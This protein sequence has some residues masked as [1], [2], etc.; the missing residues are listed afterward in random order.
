MA[1]RYHRFAP[2]LKYLVE[3]DGMYVH[4]EQ[5]GYT[6]GQEA[7]SQP[8]LWFQ[9]WQ[10]ANDFAKKSGGKVL[11]LRVYA[12]RE[13]PRRDNKAFTGDVPPA[14]DVAFSQGWDVRACPY[15]PDTPDAMFWV[16]NWW[17][18]NGEAFAAHLQGAD[19]LGREHGA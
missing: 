7:W 2:V 19:D 1:R 3:K 5:P 18:A 11:K 13:A 4:P 12:Q 14:G 6:A 9:C 17:R 15:A 16:G 8:W 10:D